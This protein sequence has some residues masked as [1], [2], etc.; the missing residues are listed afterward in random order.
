MASSAGRGFVVLEDDVVAQTK[1]GRQVLNVAG[2]EEAVASAVVGGDT[3]A[4]IGDNRKLL[5]FRSAKC[6][7]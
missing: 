4:V 1:S 6:P 5:I 3:V 2:D 7:R